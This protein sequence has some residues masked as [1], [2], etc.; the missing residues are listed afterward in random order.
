[1]RVDQAGQRS[2]LGKRISASVL[3]SRDPIIR[4]NLDDPLALD[5]DRPVRDG[6]CV[7]AVDEVTDLDPD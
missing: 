5:E 2:R 6:L 4:P 1:M 3:G 7:S